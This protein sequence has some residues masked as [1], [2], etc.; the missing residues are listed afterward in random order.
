MAANSL[1]NVTGESWK[2]MTQDFLT[3]KTVAMAISDVMHPSNKEG[4]TIHWPTTSAQRSQ[5]YT[6][7]NDLTIDAVNDADS[8]MLLDQLKSSAFPVDAMQQA[9]VTT[10]WV[11]K[12][13]R[14]SAY[15]LANEMD[16]FMLQKGVDNAYAGNNVAGATLSNTTIYT[17][18]TEANA[19]LQESNGADGALFAVI[20]PSRWAILSQSQLGNTFSGSDQSF[21]N[22]LASK[23]VSG[24][25]IYVSNNLPSTVPLTLD[26][27]PSDG[28]VFSI[29]G[30]EFTWVT[31]GTA[32]SA[33]EVNIGADLADAQSIYLLVVAGTASADYVDVAAEDRLRLTTQQV[34]A[35]AFATN[36][37]TLTAYGKI[38]ALTDMA[39][40]ANA[41][42][43]ETTQ[44][45]TG[46][47]GALSLGISK[48]VFL[49]VLPEPRQPD[50][51]NYITSVRYGG[52]VWSRD[53]FKLSVIAHTA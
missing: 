49:N 46:T 51:K 36:V 5:T 42:G 34:S 41:F 23:D 24:F 31:D 27:Q 40:G 25:E 10:E 26:T 22:G 2:A 39:G 52:T 16:Q 53:V 17:V 47:K 29:K 13:S 1:G 35:S 6:P 8:I 38:S 28:E 21:Q 33:G 37:S 44:I 48:S 43:T 30:V 3:N 14:N 19:R 12:Q 50:T 18:L 9:V 4:D 11:A 20:D 15:A 32:A 7:G 45:L